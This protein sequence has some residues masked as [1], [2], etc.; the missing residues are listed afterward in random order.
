M[1]CS[2]P[3]S[4]VH[5]FSRQEYWSGSSCPPPG[6][7]PNLG[8][9]PTCLMSPELAD[10]VFTTS[11]TWEDHLKGHSGHL[12]LGPFSVSGSKGRVDL[13]APEWAS[14]REQ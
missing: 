14:V 5:G 1:G 13:V 11:A 6:D 7:L 4:S 12:T 10:R 3:G 8:I 2:P 9:K